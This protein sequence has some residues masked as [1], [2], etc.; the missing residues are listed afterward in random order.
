MVSATQ[1]ALA[2]DLT[3]SSLWRGEPDQARFMNWLDR[4]RL[5]P[6]LP[7]PTGLPH[8]FS[9]L[10]GGGRGIRWYEAGD[11]I[12]GVPGDERAA[13]FRI[14]KAASLP[15]SAYDV[16]SLGLPIDD[17]IMGGSA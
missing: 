8:A 17:L 11:A 3:V 6:T 13:C 2:Y 1:L 4:Y 9:V 16:P 10:G 7:M 12:L 14:P 15:D 5:N